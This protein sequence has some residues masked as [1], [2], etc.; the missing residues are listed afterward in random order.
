MLQIGDANARRV[1]KPFFISTPL[2]AGF[3]PDELAL[4]HQVAL[5]S[6]ETIKFT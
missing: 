6:G 3:L 4:P 2:A 1:V 5:G